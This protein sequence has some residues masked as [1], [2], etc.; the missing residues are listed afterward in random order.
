MERKSGRNIFIASKRRG[1][2]HY[3][4]HILYAQKLSKLGANTARRWFKI[5]LNF[6]FAFLIFTMA[7]RTRLCVLFFFTCFIKY[8]K[9]KTKKF[10]AS[11]TKLSS[12]SSTHKQLMPSMHTYSI[13]KVKSHISP[14]LKVFT[15]LCF[16][17]AFCAV[18]CS[19]CVLFRFALF[20]GIVVDCCLCLAHILLFG[21]CAFVIFHE[22]RLF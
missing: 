2:L 14:L 15:L 4:H 8:H 20:C 18:S 9:N 5:Q 22:C 10:Q 21:R 6:F 17:N 13:H 11:S 16:V 12:S 3:V 1:V 7:K 19:C